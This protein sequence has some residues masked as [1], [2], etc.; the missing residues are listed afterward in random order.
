VKHYKYK[1]HTFQL[2][3]FNGWVGLFCLMWW[4]VRW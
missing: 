2:A 1:I 3:Y 4:L